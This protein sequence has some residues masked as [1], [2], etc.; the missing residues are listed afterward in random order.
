MPAAERVPRDNTSFDPTPELLA[1]MTRTDLITVLQ[2]LRFRRRGL[3][4]VRLDEGVR[5]YLIS[6][7][8]AR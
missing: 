2:D 3:C 7:L 8:S 4:V 1:D 6:R 5:D